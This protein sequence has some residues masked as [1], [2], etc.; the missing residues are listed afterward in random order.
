MNAVERDPKSRSRHRLLVAVVAVVAVLLPACSGGNDVQVT[1]GEF[2]F[3]APDD[4]PQGSVTF[5]V[6]NEGTSPHEMIVFSVP[7][8]VDPLAL[9]V[10]GGV[11]ATQSVGLEELGA[12]RGLSG[13]AS[14]EVTIDLEPGSYAMICNLPGHYS[15]GMSLAF[16]VGS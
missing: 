8:D 1:M 14:A 15:Q 7:A 3:E 9:P 5:A 12:V 13:S 6:E 10:E 11:A 16:T 2:Y 4:V